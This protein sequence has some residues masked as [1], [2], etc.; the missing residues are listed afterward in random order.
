[1]IVDDNK[2]AAVLMS[3]VLEVAGFDTFIE[4]DP[5]RALERARIERPDV[6][7]LDIGLPGMDGNELARRLRSTQGSN[8]LLAATTGYGQENDRANALAAGFDHYFVKPV[9]TKEIIALLV[10]WREVSP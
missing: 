5:Y 9:D 6:G 8:L 10:G 3:M 4:H 1:M 7:L 2:D